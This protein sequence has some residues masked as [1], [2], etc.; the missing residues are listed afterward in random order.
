MALNTQYRTQEP[1]IM[2]DFSLEGEE[3]IHALDK[4][5]VINRLLGGNKLTLHGIKQLL[6]KADSS[7]PITIADI[8]CGNGDMLR[9]LAEY[10]KKQN[11][12]FKLIGIDANAFTINYAR[13]L[14]KD[15][16]NI[17]YVCMDIFSEDFHH[18]KYDIALCTLTLHHFSNQEIEKILDLL[19]QNAAVG[20]VVND[21]HR[22]KLAYRLFEGVCFVFNLN[23]MSKNDGLVSILRG[24][25]KSELVHFS[26]KLN[27][28]NY[29][30]N[31]KWAFRYQ[32]II[33]K[34]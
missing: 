27:L 10:G 32:W 15:F 24:F 18:L 3:L 30:I 29:S 14:S 34:I 4:I 9:M 33:S 17:E 28:N 13:E 11:L 12:N 6:K 19:H 25:K 23:S 1:E 21:L 2:D 8:G 5:A 20:I 31:W 22:S 26:K 16:K 7:K